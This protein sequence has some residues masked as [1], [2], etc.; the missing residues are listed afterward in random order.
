[1]N[2]RRELKFGTSQMLS[3]DQNTLI[4]LD[5]PYFDQEELMEN[6]RV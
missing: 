1:M 4:L 3:A 5:R 6:H 2:D